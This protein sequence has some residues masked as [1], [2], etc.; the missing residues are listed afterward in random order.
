MNCFLKNVV[1]YV[2]KRGKHPK[3]D[4]NIIPNPKVNTSG[5]VGV[6]KDSHNPNYW[7]TK[8]R[9]DRKKYRK[10]FSSPDPD[11]NLKDAR[12]FRKKAVEEKMVIPYENGNANKE[13]KGVFKLF[14]L[15]PYQVNNHKFF[16]R[17]TRD[18][19]DERYESGEK[20]KLSTKI[21]IIDPHNPA[22]EVKEALE[23]YFQNDEEKVQL[24]LDFCVKA[25]LQFIHSKLEKSKLATTEEQ[26]T[27]ENINES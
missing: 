10:S 17:W 1:K 20:K 11:Q 3:I 8:W 24:H 22:P 16:I 18:S 13:G 26:K 2:A 6:S 5:V 7:I 12:A 25:M 19:E 9:V 23:M 4:Q 21:P 15:F 27:N 14:G